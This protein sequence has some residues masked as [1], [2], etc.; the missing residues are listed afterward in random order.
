MG[1]EKPCLQAVAELLVRRHS[2]GKYV[3]LTNLVLV[4]PSR[5]ASRRLLTLLAQI[6]YENQLTIEPPRVKTVGDFPELLYAQRFPFA[7]ALVQ[8]I[9]WVRAMQ[10]CAKEQ[11]LSAVIPHPP[12]FGN[13]L[14]WMEIGRDISTMQQELAADGVD[15]PKVVETWTK[16]EERGVSLPAAERARWEVLAK[17]QSVYHVMLDELKLWD[18]QSARLFALKNPHP[19]R[20]FNIRFQIGLVGCV[21]L[22][23]IQQK[24]LERISGNVEVFIFAPESQADRFTQMGCLVPEK[25]KEP[26]VD[27]PDEIISQ[28]TKPEDQAEAVMDWLRNLDGKYAAD[29]ITVGV[30]DDTLEPFISQR[31]RQEGIVS[32]YAGGKELSALGPWQLLA[33]LA[34]W[35]ENQ[36]Y[37]GFAALVRHPDMERY[38]RDVCH[39][40]VNWVEELDTFYNR[41]LPESVPTKK[42]PADGVSAAEADIWNLEEVFAEGETGQAAENIPETREI[43]SREA[44]SQDASSL[45]DSPGEKRPE[46]LSSLRK[47]LTHLGA[48]RDSLLKS[49]NYHH[50]LTLAKEQGIRNSKSAVTPS[51][52]A[53]E[54][55]E[56]ETHLA[57]IPVW[58][59]SVVDFLLKI[60][61]WRAYNPNFEKDHHVARSCL[62]IRRIL[63]EE[64][65]LPPKLTPK[66]KFTDSLRLFLDQTGKNR[67][68]SPNVPDLLE[69]RGWLELSMDDSPAMILTGFNEGIIPQSRNEHVFLPNRL[70]KELGI[71]T[72]ETRFARDMYLLSVL[73]ATRENLKIVFG[74]LSADGN[75]LLPSRL[76]LTGNDETLTRRVKMY[77]TETEAENR[78]ESA[79]ESVFETFPEPAAEIVTGGFSPLVYTETKIS[80]P[81]RSGYQVPAPMVS[82]VKKT[83]M[84]VSEFQEYLASPYRYYLKYIQK[85]SVVSDSAGELDGG[86]FGNL[87]HAVLQRFGLEE[88]AVQRAKRDGKTPQKSQD[89]EASRITRSFDLFLEEYFS[90]LYGKKSLSTVLIQK[91]QLRARLHHFARHQ[92][93]WAQDGWEIR[94]VEIAKKVPLRAGGG[95]GDILEFAGGPMII[96]GVIDRVDYHPVLGRWAILDYKTADS[97]ASPE[98][99]HHRFPLKKFAEAGI[100]PPPEEWVNLQLPLYRQLAAE[101][102]EIR[103]AGL[104]LGYILLPKDPAKSGF[105]LAGWTPIDLTAADAVAEEVIQNIRAGRFS[106]RGK[107][108]AYEDDFSW[109]M[110][111]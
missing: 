65:L 55:W 10:R 92:A 8:Q 95:A 72:N 98:T 16:M 62:E 51:A 6:A 20:D 86:Q 81:P 71:E 105:S 68:N 84:A 34:D 69:L 18:K 19:Q 43:L 56:M 93:R 17:V 57:P 102:P 70:R 23:N 11:Q 106:E 7:S 28:V 97:G 99:A 21:D 33:A 94:H 89:E 91:E 58:G 4:F 22:N 76:L 53:P 25:W 50:T 61:G 31:L 96:S 60:Y 13:I 15:F 108:P 83:H 27:L 2:Q 87:A 75:S 52:D 9:V 24:M 79:S 26:A 80:R 64:M 111:E 30:P 101:I 44:V 42:K 29:E 67:L 82:P 32:Q 41:H 39:L 35:L 46:I 103:V 49:A 77:F 78:A 36:K 14:A 66:M 1:W 59:C 73:L 40:P 38:L 47:V 12:D 63:V 54:N 3:D 37:A 107:K 45:S 109:I 90:R 5:T 74:R 100:S 48:L 110:K 104:Q 88:I 85:L